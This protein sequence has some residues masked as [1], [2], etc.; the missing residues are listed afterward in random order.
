M[1]AATGKVVLALDT[2]TTSGRALVIDAGGAVLA[3]DQKQA[4]LSTP[5]PGWVEQD[6][7]ELW[8]AP[9]ATARGALQKA[10]LT[11]A[12]VARLEGLGLLIQPPVAAAI[13]RGVHERLRDLA[14]IHRLQALVERQRAAARQAGG[15]MAISRP[16]SSS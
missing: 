5:Q 16:P 4:G 12:D 10:G 8:Q 11:A 3:S 6:A 2:G 14:A 7:E 15:E 1:A 9:L 13:G